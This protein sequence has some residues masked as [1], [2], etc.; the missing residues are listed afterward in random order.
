MADLKR[1]MIKL[2]KNPEEAAQGAEI[3]YQTYWTSPFLSS[4]VTYEAL[5]IAEKLDES[6]SDDKKQNMTQR[7]GMDLLSQ[8]VANKAYGG[9]FT[10][11][12]LKTKFHG[13]DL[14]NELQGQ[15]AFITNGMQTD[16]TK[17]FLKKKN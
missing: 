5:D 8:F 9:Q 1:N 12:D 2:V 16:D 14:I 10:P 4:D 15:L 3:E 11:E 17:K 13:P 6:T 7:E